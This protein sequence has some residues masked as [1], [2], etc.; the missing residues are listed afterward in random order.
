[1]E[2]GK[3]LGVGEPEPLH[4]LLVCLAVAHDGFPGLEH[5]AV[6]PGLVQGRDAVL[7]EEAMGEVE[8]GDE[9]GPLDADL[10]Q[11]AKIGL[12]EGRESGSEA[13][14][15]VET[16]FHRR[17]SHGTLLMETANLKMQNAK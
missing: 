8:V 16:A 13:E 9:A 2:P 5:V 10:G 7:C 4:P 14:F 1:M 6:D 17:L 3:K 12:P 11:G 15:P